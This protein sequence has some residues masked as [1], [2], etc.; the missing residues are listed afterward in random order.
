MYEIE[1][2]EFDG[3]WHAD[4]VKGDKVVHTTEGYGDEQS[5]EWAAGDWIK[6]KA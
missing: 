5:A 3:V 6:R 2:F 4:V 1:T